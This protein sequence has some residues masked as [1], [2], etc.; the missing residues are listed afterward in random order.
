[1]NG[2]LIIPVWIFWDTVTQESYLHTVKSSPRPKG[3]HKDKGS[4]VIEHLW[5]CQTFSKIVLFFLNIFRQWTQ[6]LLIAGL[7][8]HS[9]HPP[10][11]YYIIEY[12][13]EHHS[14]NVKFSPKFQ[15][16][17]WSLRKL[18]EGIWFANA[19]QSPSIYRCVEQM[20]LWSHT[21]IVCRLFGSDVRFC[22]VNSNPKSCRGIESIIR[23]SFLTEYD[24]E[25][26]L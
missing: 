20:H 5:I 11:T 26:S 1:V 25:T 16:S 8:F 19:P 18:F 14:H 4:A 24:Q 12:I 17:F 21:S 15:Q 22:R 9:G 10:I 6:I 2:L 23:E 13:I 3:G 7:I